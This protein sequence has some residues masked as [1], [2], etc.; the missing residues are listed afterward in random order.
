MASLCRACRT[1]CGVTKPYLASS[2]AKSSFSAFST[3]ITSSLACREGRRW[4]WL[5]STLAS[6]MQEQDRSI[7]YMNSSEQALRK[8]KINSWK[9]Q[10]NSWNVKP[11]HD[12]KIDQIYWKKKSKQ[13]QFYKLTCMGKLTQSLY[14]LCGEKLDI[15]SM[16]GNWV[17]FCGFACCLQVQCYR[18][19]SVSARIAFVH[20]VLLCLTSLT[21]AIQQTLPCSYDSA[22]V[23]GMKE[24]SL[25]CWLS[26]NTGF[27][28]SPLPAESPC[29]TSLLTNRSQG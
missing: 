11:W 23:P 5:D 8:V 10:I 21:S 7:G 16:K 28:Q 13:D 2:R 15:L 22:T 9:H 14:L 19:G 20:F 17:L 18:I 6:N 12:R 26:I 4:M 27:Y 1:F 3:V 29:L 25:S 24:S